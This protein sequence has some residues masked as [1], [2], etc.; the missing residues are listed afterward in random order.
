MYRAL[1]S[2]LLQR[3][4]PRRLSDV[5]V[6]EDTILLGVGLLLSTLLLSWSFPV[7]VRRGG[8]VL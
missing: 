1:R 4:R 7:R 6:A 2:K 5:H 8:L 3:S